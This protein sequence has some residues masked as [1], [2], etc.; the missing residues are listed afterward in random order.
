MNT[1][2]HL[3]GTWTAQKLVAHLGALVI[4]GGPD[5]RKGTITSSEGGMLT[6]A[7]LGLGANREPGKLESDAQ[8]YAAAEQNYDPAGPV[9]T[10]F[11]DVL[12]KDI[13]AL[14]KDCPGSIPEARKLAG[15]S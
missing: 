13:A 14:E 8:N 3:A 1:G 5:L 2:Q 12:K 15:A 7:Y 10:V 9:E 4:V 6:G 11:A